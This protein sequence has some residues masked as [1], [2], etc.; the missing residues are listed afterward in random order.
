MWKHHVNL[1]SQII[2]ISTLLLL[3][4]MKIRAYGKKNYIKLY[5]Y[6]YIIPKLYFKK[7]ILKYLKLCTAA[8]L[9]PLTNR[10][11]F[12]ATAATEKE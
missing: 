3:A 9:W 5:N 1:L 12:Q 6:N 11:M 8:S 7:V 4:M 10:E 2:N